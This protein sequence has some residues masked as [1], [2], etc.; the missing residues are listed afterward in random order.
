[1]Y[2]YSSSLKIHRAETAMVVKNEFFNKKFIN[3]LYVWINPE[4][5]NKIFKHVS[6]VYE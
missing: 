2:S 1:M 4:H 6:I 5:A 3:N